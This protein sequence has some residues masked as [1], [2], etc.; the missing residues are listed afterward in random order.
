MKQVKQSRI[1]AW[2]QVVLVA[3]AVFCGLEFTPYATPVAQATIREAK[4][5]IG[6]KAEPAVVVPDSTY[7]VKSGDQL[8]KLFGR[9][10]AAVVCEDNKLASCDH[11][12]V[13]QVLK[14]RA[15]VTPREAKA[16]TPVIAKPAAKPASE[17]TAIVTPATKP[18]IAKRVARTYKY[19]APRPVAV[20]PKTN[21]AGEILYRRVGTAPLNGCGKKNVATVS[22]EAWEVLG[23][24]NDDREYLREHADLANGPRIHFTVAEGLHQIE[25]DVRL[26]KVTFCRAG[27]ATAIGPMRTAW[28][29]KE[30]VYGER[31]MLPSGKT[32]VWMRNCFNWVILPE[33]KT[34]FAPPPP[35]AEP[36]V[37]ESP[38]PEPIAIEPPADERVPATP[39]AEVAKSFCNRFDP[40]LVVGQEHEPRHD[41]GDQADSN[42]LAAALYCTWRNEDDDGTHGLGAKLTASS[43]SGTVNQ[44]AGKYAGHMHLVGPAY[45]YISDDGWD[46]EVSVPMVGKLH[47]RFHQDKY[48]SRRDFTLAGISAGYNNYERRLRGEPWF[49]ETQVFGTAAVPLSRAVSHSWDGQPI[50][51]TE[52]LSRF[53]VYA[54]AGVRWWL[55]ED[56]DSMVLP[57]LQLGYF[58]ETPSSESMSARLG[59][60]DVN[61]ICGIGAGVDHDLKRGGD[62]LAR[63]WW[64]DVVKGARV[65]RSAH[66][67]HQMVVEAA[68]RGITVEENRRGYIESIRFG[69]TWKGDQQ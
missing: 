27:K 60:A 47:E 5:I 21:E 10:G 28:D 41:G 17:T 9:K 7:T 57:Y 33:E 44:R 48:E 66:R 42:F 22:E 31:F 50:T 24:S 12:R 54:N 37:A 53:G 38:P 15:G 32:L 23:L 59:I 34:V 46:A 14:L 58:L 11:I 62:V 56:E 13:G 3:L 8:L 52:E 69:D 68:D 64:C 36:P 29:A 51:D 25:T 6:T 45:E 20:V 26:E 1:P 16:A 4:G 67:K 19:A 43:W 55:Y 39:V 40:H 61:R 63:G 30:S 2:L 18:V 49:P 35:P 65:G